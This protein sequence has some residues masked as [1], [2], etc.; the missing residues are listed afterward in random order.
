MVSL[1]FR[2][3]QDANGNENRSVSGNLEHVGQWPWRTNPELADPMLGK[4]IVQVE[5]TSLPMPSLLFACEVHVVT[6]T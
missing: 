6:K 5:G 4:I 1:E 3:S 2:S